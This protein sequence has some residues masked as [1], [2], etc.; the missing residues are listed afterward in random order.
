[1]ALFEPAKSV[2]PKYQAL[3][4]RIKEAAQQIKVAQANYYPSLAI[5]AGLSSRYSSSSADSYFN[6][7]KNNLGKSLGFTLNIP[8]FNQFQTRNQVQ[9]ARLNLEESKLL[10]DIALNTL[11][12]NTARA[13]FDLSATAQSVRNLQE[14]EQHYAE[15]FRIAQVQFDEGASN[16]VLYLTAKNKLDAARNQLLMKK[17]QYLLQKFMNDFYAGSLD[18]L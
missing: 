18:L 7:S 2:L 16:S 11:R 13:V 15:S 5:H 12:E 10:K 1:M 6:Q 3:D 4:W 9:R 8:I 17:Y 14:Q